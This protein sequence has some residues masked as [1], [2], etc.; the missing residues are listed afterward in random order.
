MGH[1]YTAA[2]GGF[3]SEHFAAQSVDVSE[4]LTDEEVLKNP[5]Y[6]LVMD[7]VSGVVKTEF[8]PPTIR[9]ALKS[10]YQTAVGSRG[11]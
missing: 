3:L 2:M 4:K 1:S 9:I 10:L 6:V 8:I 5:Q 11:M 7:R